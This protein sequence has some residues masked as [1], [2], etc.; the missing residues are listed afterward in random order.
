M[1]VT[2]SQPVEVEVSAIRISVPVRYDEEDM[3]KDYPHRTGDVWTVTV[4]VETGQIRDWP[5]G[6]EPR[7]IE[8]KVVDGGT[9]ELLDPAGKVVAGIEQDYV[10]DCIPGD[11]GDYIDFKIDATGRIA[12][13]KADAAAIQRSFLGDE[14]DD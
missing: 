8:M 7:D 10:P 14:D 9:Y 2:K 4:D 13:W 6:V 3:P 5:A 12:N 11:Y 1:I